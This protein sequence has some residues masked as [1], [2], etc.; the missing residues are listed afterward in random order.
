MSFFKKKEDQDALA[1]SMQNAVIKIAS[2]RFGHP[3]SKD[4][5]AKVRQKK[6]SYMGL[7][8][9]IDTV[10]SIEISKIENYLSRLD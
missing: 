6:W 4:L 8:M 5:L 10:N 1:L 9:I 2:E 7:E 3:L